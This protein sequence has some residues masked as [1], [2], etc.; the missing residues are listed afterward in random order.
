MDILRGYINRE[1]ISIVVP[2]GLILVE[3][4]KNPGQFK[5]PQRPLCSVNVR[6][7]QFVGMNKLIRYEVYFAD[8]LDRLSVYLRGSF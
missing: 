2:F 3:R 1:D 4:I 6:Q 5:F 8:T 7:P